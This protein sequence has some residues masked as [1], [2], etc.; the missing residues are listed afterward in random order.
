MSEVKDLAAQFRN[1]LELKR[2]ELAQTLPNPEDV[3]RFIRVAIMSVNMNPDLL[4]CTPA[5]LFAAM[6]TAAKDGLLPD[7]REAVIQPRNY[8]IEEP[9]QPTRYERRA[10]YMPMVRGLIQIM[11]RSG[12]VAMIDG[13]AVRANDKFV[14]HRGDNPHIEH[15]PYFGKG[16]AGEVIGAYVVIKLTN[17]EVKREVMLHSEIE[18]VRLASSQPNSGVWKNWYDQQAI[19]AV[20]KRAQ[21]QLPTDEALERAIKH[22]NEAMGFTFDEPKA[23]T[24]DSKAEPGEAGKPNRLLGIIAEQTA[25]PD[26]PAEDA[27]AIVPLE[28]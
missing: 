2:K 5:S 13:V 22:D 20:I 4:S 26:A 3:D 16:D 10:S 28:F 23:A 19:K 6:Q 14:Y 11:Y 18:Q 25:E 27:D 8:K 9:G 21:K 1:T 15:E 12:K 24:T 7:G 17:G